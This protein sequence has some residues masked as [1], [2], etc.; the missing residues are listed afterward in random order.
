MLNC[1][2]GSIR[3]ESKFNPFYDH[4]IHESQS[5]TAN[6]ELPKSRKLPRMLG[7]GS[8]APHQHL[9]PRDMCRQEAVDTVSEEVKRRFD[10]SDIKLIQD[11][12]TLLL[13]V[14]GTVTHTL[15]DA[16]VR[17]FEGD[18]EVERLKIQL[19]MLPDMI[20]TA[21]NGSIRQATNVRTIAD[22]MM[23]SEIYQNMLCEVNKVF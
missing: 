16:L 15:S 12:E 19:G 3:N 6:S 5:L 8:S 14:N 18:I 23:Q 9:S 10:Q 11:V 1:H 20:K 4:V 22:A 21:L 13:I 7:H 17:F 2:L